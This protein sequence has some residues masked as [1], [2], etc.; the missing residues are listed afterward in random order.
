MDEFPGNC[1]DDVTP[2]PLNANVA[3]ST[4]LPLIATCTVVP[5]RPPAG[6]TDV[7]TGGAVEATRKFA[8]FEYNP[9]ASSRTPKPHNAGLVNNDEG[10]VN[11]SVLSLTTIGVRSPE[12]GPGFVL[13]MPPGSSRI[14]GRTIEFVVNLLPWIVTVTVF[15]PAITKLGLIDSIVMPPA[16]PDRPEGNAH[17]AAMM[18]TRK[19]IFIETSRLASCNLDTS[20]SEER[21][22]RSLRSPY[23]YFIGDLIATWIDLRLKPL[24]YLGFIRYDVCSSF[25]CCVGCVSVV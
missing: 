11:C 15:E 19:R 22:A 21:E 24:S 1:W 16:W 18:L 17:I 23:M 20:A 2:A 25:T 9:A 5:G 13:V 4:S 8:R 3:P 12:A 14:C 6:T 10:I 7:T